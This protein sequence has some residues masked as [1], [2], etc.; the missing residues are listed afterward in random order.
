M[1]SDGITLTSGGDFVVEASGNVTI[2]GSQVDINGG[3]PKNPASPAAAE[4][5]ED[6]TIETLENNKVSVALKE[7]EKMDGGKAKEDITLGEIK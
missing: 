6:P 5:P 3:P 2:K 7:K 4:S 1:N